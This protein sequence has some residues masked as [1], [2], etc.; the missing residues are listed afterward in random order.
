MRLTVVV[1][2][3]DYKS[4]AGARI[5]YDR[6]AGR[7]SDRG[8]AL[9]IEEIGHFNPART[10]SD[11]VLISK[12]HDARSLMFAAL[13][14]DR[15]KLVGVDLFDDYFSQLEDSRLVRYR[16][17][18]ADL[19]PF[20]Q[21]AL[22]STEPMAEVV[23]LYR[24]D[25]PVLVMNDPAPPRWNVATSTRISEKI[26]EA[27]ETRT[28]QLAWFGVGDNTYFPIGLCDLATCAP[29]LNE[30]RRSGFDI[31]LTVLTNARAL[32]PDGLALINGL[33]V[34]TR[35]E[36]WSEGAERA[37]LTDAFAVLLPVN[38]QPFSV[39]K[40]LNRAVTA[41]SF[42]CQILSTGFPLYE[43][44][45]DLLYRD[46]PSL[47]SDLAAGSMRLSSRV[48]DDVRALLEQ[49]ASP[50]VEAEALAKFL[51]LQAP[52]A[53]REALLPILIHGHST[54]AEAH[55]TV[56]ALGGLSVGSP[57][58]AAPLDFDVLFRGDADG[59]RM[60]VSRRA[61]T[62]LL[63]AARRR[64]KGQ[65]TVRGEDYLELPRLQGI[66]RRKSGVEGR[67]GLPIA[68]QLAVYEKWMSE[69]EESSAAAFGP[70]RIF[71]SETSPLFPDLGRAA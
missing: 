50:E 35:V 67:V 36:E 63:P 24:R 38:A 46:V 2:S 1:P 8:I 47:L 21:F 60:F 12:C 6:I 39:A 65:T 5:R 27:R 32:G 18:L 49:L 53:P 54:R 59:L 15:G 17:W 4:F 58:C 34:P 62:R 56:Q 20:C 66:V 70:S 45:D 41:L 10:A 28:V 42:G 26:R 69:I 51:D 71:R 33:P 3:E 22:C 31:D 37:L 40:S 13:L 68:F 43:P 64:L 16:T 9:S 14:R 30:F 25:L 57:F 61:A 29:V 7:L 52:K 48:V 55:R 44:F 11:A 23:R 19:V